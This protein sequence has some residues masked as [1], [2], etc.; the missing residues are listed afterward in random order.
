MPAAGA[1]GFLTVRI[2]LRREKSKSRKAAS[3]AGLG[4]VTGGEQVTCCS[5]SCAFLQTACK[6][7]V[8]ENSCR[9][10]GASHSP[11]VETGYRRTLVHLASVRP[12]T[13][14]ASLLLGSKS[15]TAIRSGSLA[16]CWR[17]RCPPVWKHRQQEH[18]GSREWTW[19]NIESATAQTVTTGS[20]SER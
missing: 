6:Q 4:A 7:E 16:F 12:Q 5:L 8:G 3:D 15:P 9:S 2:R 17:S 14:S 18:V 20:R 13:G 1:I 10:S 19:Q 11:A